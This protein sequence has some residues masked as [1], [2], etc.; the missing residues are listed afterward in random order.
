MSEPYSTQI[1]ARYG[2]FVSPVCLY[3]EILLIYIRKFDRNKASEHAKIMLK[4]PKTEI[5][6]IIKYSAIWGMWHHK[7]AAE[8]V[9]E[10]DQMH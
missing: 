3:A 8:V 1:R 10:Q 2:Y 9:D 6:K 5:E 7:P 4:S